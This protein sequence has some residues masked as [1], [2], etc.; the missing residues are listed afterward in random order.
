MEALVP[1]GTAPSESCP[2]DRAASCKL[3]RYFETAEA[4]GRRRAVVPGEKL[5]LDHNLTFEIVV[6]NATTATG[7]EVDVHFSGRRDN[8]AANDLSV[9]V[10]VTFGDFK[11]FVGGDSTS[12]KL[13]GQG[14]L[15]AKRQFWVSA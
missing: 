1:W 7:N 14:P 12:A 2:A 6:A 11:Y 8:C 3:M 10:L 4:G 15:F 5:V 13:F 9:G